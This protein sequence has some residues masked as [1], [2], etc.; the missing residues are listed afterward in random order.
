MFTRYGDFDSIGSNPALKA[1]Y[2]PNNNIPLI[3]FIP[4]EDWILQ[5]SISLEGI[6]RLTK[7][8]SILQI[9]WGQNNQQL[10]VQGRGV[11]R[12]ARRP[13]ASENLL[14]FTMERPLL[15]KFCLNNHENLD[16]N[17]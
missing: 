1:T 11:P 13:P 6:A 15:L 14:G 2:N 3:R 17:S 12:G 10:R 7:N 16:Y 5:P 8:I 9:G 4:S